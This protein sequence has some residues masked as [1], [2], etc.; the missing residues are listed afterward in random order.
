MSAMFS[1]SRGLVLGRYEKL[2]R[3]E[4][5]E[6]DQ[7]SDGASTVK[8]GSG[9]FRSP[10]IRITLS[11]IIALETAV[12][13]FV[14]LTA[15]PYS[16]SAVHVPRP[17]DSI[18]NGSEIFSEWIDCGQ[19]FSE[20]RNRGCVWDLM[21]GLWI[22]ES[23]FNGVMMDRYLRERNHSFYYDRELTQEMSEEEA[24]RGEVVLW[25]DAGFHHRHF[26]LALR[27]DPTFSQCGFPKA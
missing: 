18:G 22:H 25:G 12:L 27:M 5:E 13:V 15:M 7:S 1:T 9:G 2:D 24:R 6:L 14:L 4:T 16:E 17:L 8:P 10:C 19:S 21:L 23:C 11:V 26:V 20:A 3:D